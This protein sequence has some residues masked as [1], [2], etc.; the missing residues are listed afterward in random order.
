MKRTIE[1]MLTGI[2]VGALLLGTTTA[3]F[4]EGKV[5]RRQERQ[6]KRIGNGVKNG[7]LTA[8]ETAHIEKQESNL[9]KEVRTDRRANGGTLTPQERQQVNQQQNGLSREIYREKHDGEGQQQ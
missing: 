3:A 8:G 2:A 6:Q 9:N 1:R 7:S 4:A 5:A